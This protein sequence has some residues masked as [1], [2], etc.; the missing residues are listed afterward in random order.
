LTVKKIKDAF[1]H[2]KQFLS[3]MEE[4]DPYAERSLQVC[5]TVDRDTAC[6]RCLY[7]EKKKASFQ[8]SLVQFLK[9]VDKL[10]SSSTSSQ[11]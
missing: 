10:P 11:H 6:Y 4:C 9:K 8:L 7:Q 2:L 3:V 5:R 1:D